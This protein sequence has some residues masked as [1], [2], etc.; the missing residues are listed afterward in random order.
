MKVFLSHSTKDKQFVQSLAKELESLPPPEYGRS[1]MPRFRAA[2]GKPAMRK[3]KLANTM[4]KILSV[5]DPDPVSGYP[6]SYARDDIPKN[7][8]YPDGQSVPTPDA[9]RERS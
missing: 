3:L 5:L 2:G 7:T 1:M 4:A 9:A 6:T 8:G